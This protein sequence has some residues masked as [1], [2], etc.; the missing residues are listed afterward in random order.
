MTGRNPVVETY[1]RLATEYD[2][3]PNRASCWGRVTSDVLAQIA[4]KAARGTV[5]DVGCGTGRELA[6]VA[7]TCAPTVEFIGVEPAPKMREV[8]AA[9]TAGHPNVRILP[10]SFEQLPL[11]DESVDYLYSILAF[12][13]TTDLEQALAELR[14]VLRPDAE[15]DLF[16]IGRENGKEF[17][18]ATTPVFFQFLSPA[19]M[20]KAAALRKQLT[21]G[22][23]TE[24]FRAAF[25]GGR[26]TVDES[27]VTYYDTLE[28][29]WGWWVRI[30]GQFIEIP[31]ETRVECDA[32]VREAL[33]KLTDDEGIPYTVH[34][35]HVR[36]GQQAEP[37]PEGG[38][39]R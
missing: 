20:L 29:H 27:F 38:G 16:F 18:R 30:E 19:T 14:R 22:Q 34:L 39:S 17:I 13:W 12:H 8:A 31:S 5:V 7:A 37:A 4:I 1:S 2:S 11:E 26:L 35:L 32:A 33:A 3:D 23:A 9:R 6:H 10:G 28:G 21:L 36:L 15:M 24:L 25:P